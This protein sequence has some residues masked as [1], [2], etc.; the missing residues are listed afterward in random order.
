MLFA[1]A[2]IEV[3][4]GDGCPAL[5]GALSFDISAFRI[6][7]KDIQINSLF[8]GIVLQGNG[9]GSTWSGLSLGTGSS[10][11]TVR[12]LVIRG[13]NAAI[14]LR[15]GSDGNTI[16]GN[17]IGALQADG[18]Y[19]SATSAETTWGVEVES[20]NNTIGGTTAA[21]R[22]VISGMLNAGAGVSLETTGA[23]GNRV[24]GNYLGTNASGTPLGV[25]AEGVITRV[26][27]FNNMIG[28]TAAGEGNLIAGA[29]LRGIWITPDSGAGNAILGNSIYSNASLGIDLGISDEG[30]FAS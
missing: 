20:A 7:W 19:T 4:D 13:F 1:A 21:D 6:D 25:G 8:N 9:S 16:V 23:T 29:A 15:A 5:D 26:G 2:G 28:G 10:G 3:H 14:Y 27:A 30:G 24:I 12:G 18:T 11:S 17:Y 22:N